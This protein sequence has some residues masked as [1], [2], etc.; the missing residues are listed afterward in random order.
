MRVV[1]LNGGLVGQ[2]AQIFVLREMPPDDVGQRARHEEILLLEA[3]LA[4]A[5]EF[6]GRI[7]NRR[8]G[9][10]QRL[11]E[12][13]LLVVALVEHLQIE[14]RRCTRAP[15]PQ[16]VD[17]TTAKTNDRRIEWHAHDLRS[18][19]PAHPRLA[20]FLVALGAPAEFHGDRVLGPP[21]FPRVAVA[22]PLV[23][24]LDLPAVANQLIEDAE[25]VADAVAIAG[26]PQRGHRIQ[27]ARRQ[28]PE[29]AIAEAG[30]MLFLEQLAEIEA[31]GFER[32]I[33][34]I[35]DAEIDHVVVERA[36]HQKFGRQVVHALDVAEIVLGLGFDPFLRQPI[37][38]REGERQEAVEDGGADRVFDL[39]V[40][41]PRQER[42]PNG[43]GVAAG[44]GRPQQ[45][46]F[47]W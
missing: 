16:I 14:F 23:G 36:A 26:D 41:Q 35:G 43:F 18:V 25:L 46:T 37:A 33:A 45:I 44:R 17:R 3:Q 22:Q 28:A 24:L 7:Q 13:R 32:G 47:G 15:Q 42:H 34:R 29:A 39:R 11:V 21:H 8:D 1:E 20:V 2:V 40:E 19:D 5:L 27:K 6:V 10:R 30:V 38:H 9:F 12:H 31:D 4:A